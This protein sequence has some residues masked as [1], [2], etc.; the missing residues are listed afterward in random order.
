MHLMDFQLEIGEKLGLDHIAEDS[1]LAIA[2]VDASS[3]E[4]AVSNN[5]SICRN[6]NPDGKFNGQCSAFCGTAFEE[7]SEVGSTVS[8]TCHAGLACRVVPV[9][10]RHNPLVVIVGRTFVKAENYRDATNRAI[11]GDWS[12]YSPS[13]FFENILLTGSEAVLTKTAQKVAEVMAEAEVAL[14]ARPEPEAPIQKE[15]DTIPVATARPETEGLP[16]DEPIAAPIETTDKIGGPEPLPVVKPEPPRTEP[17]AKKKPEQMSA[18]VERFNREIRLNPQVERPE[19]VHDAK[20]KTEP[21]PEPI[22]EAA[23]EIEVEQKAEAVEQPETTPEPLTEPAPTPKPAERRTAEASAWRSFFGSILQTDYPK[24][25]DSILEFIALH[26]GF[27]ALLWLEK[28]GNRLEN[29]AAYGEMKTRKVRLGIAS[30]DARL[31]EALQN[32]RPLELGERSK[33]DET[34][35]SRTMNLFP[36]GVGGGI[37][38]A[39]AILDPLDD[40]K[41]KLQIARICHSLAPQLEILRLRSE[42]ALGETL[43]TS[44]RRFGESLKRI[45]ADD[46]WVNLTQT[47]AEMLR[48]ERASLLVF[49][50]KSGTLELKAMIGAKTVNIEGEEIGGRVAKAVFTRNEPVAVYDVAK[51]GLSPAPAGRHYK[52]SSFLSCPIAIGGRTIGVMNFADRV[53]GQPFD[54]SSLELFQSI[55]PQLA[56]AIDRASLKEKAGEFEQLSVTDALTGL[57]NRRYIE[58][59]LMEEVKRSNR[60]GFPMSFMMLDV[61][62]FKS[63]NDQFGHPAGDVALKLVA[64]VIRETL[65]GADVAARYGGEEF[66]ILLPQTTSDEAETIAE[67]IRANVETADFPCRRVTISIGVASY[68]AELCSSLGLVSAAD[69]ALY[70]AKGKGRNRVSAFE[71][72]NPE[73]GEQE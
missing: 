69:K 25:V 37:S 55:A 9:S 61:D 14:P 72:M 48:A 38:A 34:A 23:I 59:R 1:G 28:N 21:V 39:I 64:H 26:Y 31:I 7:A 10:Y 40:D 35:G 65:R 58:E 70:E 22:R 44:V 5:N 32:E 51:T 17:P 54:R 33:D 49:D 20:A 68:S 62:N 18:L 52:T 46:L 4:I 41:T 43:S 56:V 27:K 42:V 3:L 8:F 13:E 66:S 15:A 67:R 50:P 36:I 19:P 71:E 45:D 6:L 12:Q 29:S 63:Y 47:A 24:A 60:H 30:D 2:V 57:L 73:I 11:S 16:H 53:S